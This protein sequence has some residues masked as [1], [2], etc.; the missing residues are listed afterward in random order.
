MAYT[1]TSVSVSGDGSYSTPV[2]QFTP[3]AIGTYYWKASFTSSSPNTTN[4]SH[5]GDCSDTQEDATI[6]DV[7]ST[8]TT[9]QSWVPNDSARVAAAAG[10]N[11]DGTV[12][13]EFFA[14]GTCTGSPEWS[15][16]VDVSGASP[17]TV[18]TTNEEAID[19]SGSFSWRVTYD[20]DNPAQRDI[21]ATCNEVSSLTI[22][23]DN[24]TP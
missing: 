8:M 19:A 4:A 20:S 21:A 13:F 22:D 9:A 10:G 17:Q 12:T 5:N 23:N 15:Q 6:T 24:T 14:N 18:S 16:D 11:L 3:S 2:G 1:S 7:A